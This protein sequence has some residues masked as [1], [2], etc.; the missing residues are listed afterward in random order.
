MT[1]GYLNFVKPLFPAIRRHCVTVGPVPL[2]CFRQELVPAVLGPASLGLLRA[3]RPLLAVGVDRDAA[4]LDT[5]RHEIVH[6]PL[7]ALLAEGQIVLVGA[8][9]VAVAL[10]QNEDVGVGLETGGV[11][12]E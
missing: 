8:P 12:V 5:V 6:G 4:G 3:H 2:A 9:L 1:W 7:G 11:A 10:A